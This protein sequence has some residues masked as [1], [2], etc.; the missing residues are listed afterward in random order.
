M[1]KLTVGLGF[2]GLD[3]GKQIGGETVQRN[4]QQGQRLRGKLGVFEEN[5]NS[6]DRAKASKREQLGG[7]TSGRH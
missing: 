1:E 2:E 3:F 5:E 7:K 6:F 4:E